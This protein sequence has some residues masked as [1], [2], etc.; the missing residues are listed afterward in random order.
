MGK[1]GSKNIINSLVIAKIRS[2][3]ILH[4]K[5]ILFYRDAFCV[6]NGTSF[7]LKAPLFNVL[8]LFD[9]LLIELPTAFYRV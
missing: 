6:L 9:S 7:T 5:S 8:K 2:A 3:K 4:K 1:P